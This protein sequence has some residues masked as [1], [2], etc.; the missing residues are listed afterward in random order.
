MTSAASLE[1]TMAGR[2]FG[3]RELIAV[4]VDAGS[5]TSWDVP[6]EQGNTAADYAADLE[7]ARTK[8]GT[9]EAVVTGR[10]RIRGHD[11]A[12]IVSEFRFL[13]GS[14]G[15]QTAARITA[16]VRRATA[17]RLPLLAAPASGGTRMQEGTPAFVTMIEISRAVVDHKAAGLPHLV[18]LRHPTTGGVLAS[19]GSLGH[20][21]I[22]EPGAL[23]GFLGPSVYEA[24]EG[25]PFPSGVQQAENLVA[26]GVIDG[27]VPLSS[28][29]D[30]AARTLAL[31]IGARAH[32]A[33]PALVA[34]S[35]PAVAALADEVDAAE[36]RDRAEGGYGTWASIGHTRRR[37]RPGVRE[38]LRYG[39]DAFMPVAGHRPDAPVRGLLCAF[40]SI[41]GTRCV[42]IGQDRHAQTLR[43]SLGPADL[44]VAR[45]MIEVAGE[46][47]LPLVCVVDT[48]GADLSIAA[49]EGGLA[50]EIARTLA[51]LV[52]ARVPSVS[53]LL[54]QGGGGAALALFAG[55]RVVAAEH[56]WL[57]PLPPEGASTILF[58]TTSRA[59]ETAARQR[60]G[61]RALYLDGIVHAVV[62]EPRPAH[63][64]P[65]R[66]CQR[67]A[68]EVAVQLARQLYTLT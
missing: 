47:S 41:G 42:V 15:R 57:S 7:R 65:L 9:D 20:F 19:W 1:P 33:S 25:R 24:L 59:G 11:V 67:I 55:R 63:E 17:E 46:L 62:P 49:E 58:G 14:I 10:A 16:A 56:A 51:D 29:A 43:G 37:D 27:V 12:L 3:A 50:A 60:V 35:A 48:P 4:T 53:V 30:V 61:A 31:L 40:A 64:D 23:V 52:T 21:T 22:A 68:D 66:F 45:R 13:G 5:W 39:A 2:R 18:Y 44:R 28:L 36:A 32:A 8:A 26:R 54:G 34:R 6:P 38:F